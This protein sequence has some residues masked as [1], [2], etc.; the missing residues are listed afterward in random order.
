M[1]GPTGRDG[2]AC[3]QGW[4]RNIGGKKMRP[5]KRGFR[6]ADFGSLPTASGLFFT[7]NFSVQA[8]P[9]AAAH[10]AAAS[11]LRVYS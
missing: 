2:V 11:S 5:F 3:G 10:A 8:S 7:P 4:D 9:S 1:I 6:P